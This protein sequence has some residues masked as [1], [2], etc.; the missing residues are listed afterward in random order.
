MNRS[1]LSERKTAASLCLA[2]LAFVSS[3]SAALVMTGDVQQSATTFSPTWTVAPSLI[4]GQSPIAQAGT[5]TADGAT[6][7]IPALT[8]GV[9][10]PVSTTA[11]NIYAAGGPNAGTAVTYALPAQA[12]GYNVTNIT[13]YS[14]WSNGGRIGQGYTVLYSTVADPGNF[15]WLTNVNYSAGFSGNNPNNP[16]SLQVQLSDSAGGVIA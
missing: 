9:I 11:F 5:F 15:I 7:G 6:T 10:G 16:I 1:Q 14:G 2:L 4:A 3:T 8:D 13:V 12:N